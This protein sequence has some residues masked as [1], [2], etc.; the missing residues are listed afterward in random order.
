MGHTKASGASVSSKS[1]GKTMGPGP[2]DARHRA[3]WCVAGGSRRL[4][5]R[6][7]PRACGARDAVASLLTALAKDYLQHV[8]RVITWSVGFGSIVLVVSGGGGGGS[9]RALEGRLNSSLNSRVH[10]RL[11]LRERAF[12]PFPNPARRSAGAIRL[13]VIAIITSHHQSSF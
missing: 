2:V 12:P 6:I 1:P 13:A 7:P 10:G 11:L 8:V 4:R 5:V 9:V 3:V